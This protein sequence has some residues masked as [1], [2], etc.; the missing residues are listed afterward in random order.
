MAT[1]RI[2]VLIDGT[3]ESLYSVDF[4]LKYFNEGG[5]KIVGISL[6]SDPVEV[7]LLGERPGS[8]AELSNYNLGAIR[9]KTVRDE[10]SNILIDVKAVLE[11]RFVLKKVH[12]DN[13]SQLESEVKYADLLI[14]TQEAYS[15]L[16]WVESDSNLANTV[17]CCPKVVINQ[18][19]HDIQNVILLNDG[20]AEAIYSMKSFCRFFDDTCK[21]KEV[22]LLNYMTDEQH[23]SE[24]SSDLKMLS[25]YLQTHCK[26]LA[27]ISYKSESEEYLQKLLQTNKET[28]VVGPDPLIRS[29]DDLFTYAIK[30]A[31]GTV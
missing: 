8:S 18:P 2:L 27:F 5:N 11:S 22:T 23:D 20:S 31:V 7:P 24:A 3:K 13:K 30:I 29:T 25:G 21:D 19:I 6:D 4:A 14:T 1:G 17:R 10:L 26:K 12:V 9:N 16:S 15:Q 28:V